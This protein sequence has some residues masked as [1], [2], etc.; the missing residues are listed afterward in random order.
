M[1]IIKTKKGLQMQD[2]TLVG[3]LEG[4]FKLVLPKTDSIMVI[5]LVITGIYY[6][7]RLKFVQF[8]MLCSVFKLLVQRHK[9]QKDEHIS[10]FAALMISTASRV[11]I[12]NIAGISV[13]LVLGGAGALFWMWA[14]AFF[15]GASAFAESALAQVY[16]SKDSVSGGFK[17]GPAYYIKKALGIGWLAIFF[18]IILII[19]YAYGFN[20][21]QSYTMTSAFKVY[22]DMYFVGAETSFDQ[23][24]MS[25]Y[26]GVLLSAFCAWL[27]FSHHTKIGKVSSIIV[28]IMAIGY[29]FL[30]FIV[31]VLNLEKLPEVFSLIFKQAF[32]FEAIF[33]GFAGSA[34][35]IGIKRG[36]Y[37]NEA[38]MGSAPNAAAAAITSHPAKQGIIQSFA[39]FIDVIVCT[40]T[41]LLVL[42]SEAYFA[43]IGA[44]GKP[45]L[46]ALPL[47]Q[48]VMREHYGIWGLHFV[49]IAVVLFAVTS[50]IGNYY[51]AQANV[52]YL[53]DS[54]LIMNVFRFSAVAM[55]FIGSQMN[56]SLAWDFAD[57]TMA[58]MA[59]TNIISILLLSGIVKKVLDDYL[60]QKKQGID[61]H[62]SATKLGIKN[63]ECWN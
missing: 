59:T 45:L 1:I 58:F 31:V 2:F 55:V 10:P 36:L 47:V 5:L 57:F 63:A 12:G 33:G 22:Y 35:V 44:D 17:G 50:L 61:P 25:I 4:F 46:S 26:I 15:G 62:F 29:T 8:T 54:R 40:S 14:M 16:K 48:E 51:Y 3:L 28:P 23:S 39:V 49:S 53:T 9:D 13:A 52:K 18:A 21:L 56:I 42:F 7:F 34:L 43:N 20:G 24:S 19:T 32:D 60:E 37:S 11:G 27:F 6:S 38:G 41:G 30:A